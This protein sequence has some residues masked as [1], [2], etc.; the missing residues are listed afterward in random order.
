MNRNELNFDCDRPAKNDFTATTYNLATGLTN[1]GS[2]EYYEGKKK[3]VES[4]DDLV[5][6]GSLDANE[7]SHYD[8]WMKYTTNDG[9][10]IWYVFELKERNNPSDYYPTA[11]I[12]EEKWPEFVTYRDKGIIPCWV[13]LYTDNK[14]RIWNLRTTDF[15]HLKCSMRFIKQINIDP[16][17]PKKMQIRRE[18]PM[19][20]G[21]LL[22]RLNGN[23]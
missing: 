3:C 16:D 23:V 9:S 4:P 10:R 6:Y 15:C 5:P 19:E 7:K 17:S 2:I 18:I 8:I 22:E 1:Y 12:N 14:I 20:W 11:F 21:N 13:E